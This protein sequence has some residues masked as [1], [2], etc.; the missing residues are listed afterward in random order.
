M[1]AR[2]ARHTAGPAPPLIGSARAMAATTSIP[3]G[4]GLGWEKAPQPL[5]PATRP[6]D[7]GLSA[8]VH[9]STCLPSG[10]GGAGETVHRLA[11]LQQTAG[12]S[13]VRM[14]PRGPGS[15]HKLLM[16]GS[17]PGYLQD[18]EV[19]KQN[20]GWERSTLGRTRKEPA[21]PGKPQA[22]GVWGGTRGAGRAGLLLPGQR[23]ASPL[24]P[25]GLGT[26]HPQGTGVGGRPSGRLP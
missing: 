12:G 8:A 22:H 17:R 23:S 5:E 26:G 2:P 11:R 15:V 13:H 4:G 25:P 19:N 6:G 7:Q 9:P 16:A 14:A 1:S 10:P 3:A 18:R 21:P 24:P 20:P